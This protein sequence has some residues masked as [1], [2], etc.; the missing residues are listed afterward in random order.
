MIRPLVALV[1]LSASTAVAQIRV[2]GRIVD[3]TGMTPVQ[4]A[5]VRVTGSDTTMTTGPSG[6]F[7]FGGLIPGRMVLTVSAVGRRFVSM[8][9]ELLA[10]TVVT[11]VMRPQVIALDPMVVRPGTIRIKGTT[12]DSLT[13][14]YIWF[15]QAGIYP[16]E[17]FVEASNGD[18]KF[19]KVAPGPVT[20][21]V[22]AAEYLP[23]VIHL[24]ARRDTSIRVK[25]LIDSIALRMIAHQV[26]RLANRADASPYVVQGYN[27]QQLER[28]RTPAVGEFV[29]RKLFMTADERRRFAEMSADEAC[30]FYD[31]RRIPPG[32]LNG[33]LPDL[34]E[35]VEVYRNGG[36]IRVYSK[37]YVRSLAAK[38]LLPQAT[39]IPTG[40]RPLCM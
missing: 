21:V 20:I 30:I 35:R 37:R 14:E 22:E 23:A 6:T 13:G 4:G 10:D 27:R 18:F 16:A 15:A 3:E 36:M 31:D 7:S 5:S 29:Y 2:S 38:E 8:P 32:M 11:I 39:F 26:V 1:V 24:N 28:E 12:I 33:I 40:L 34:V 9:L 17:T 25:M 19:D